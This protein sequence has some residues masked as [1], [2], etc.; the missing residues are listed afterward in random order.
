M[1]GHSMDAKKLCVVFEVHKFEYANDLHIREVLR[2]VVTTL[3]LLL[4]LFYNANI[5]IGIFFLCVQ[6]RVHIRNK[7]CNT[8]PF[9]GDDMYMHLNTL[10]IGPGPT[11]YCSSNFPTSTFNDTWWTTQ[12][13]ASTFE[14][15][16][17]T[18]DDDPAPQTVDSQPVSLR[19]DV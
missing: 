1:S 15:G 8:K 16:G 17:H 7:T 18:L 6:R 10:Y 9:Y 3:L 19:W 11:L 2:Y 4:S 12:T 13:R 14:K 5:T